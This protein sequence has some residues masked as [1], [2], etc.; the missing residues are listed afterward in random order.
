MLKCVFRE[1]INHDNI[2][3]YSGPDVVYYFHDDSINVMYMLAMDDKGTHY[4]FTTLI[5][6]NGYNVTFEEWN[7]ARKS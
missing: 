7:K 6:E 3:S 2:K 4:P 1:P 5:D